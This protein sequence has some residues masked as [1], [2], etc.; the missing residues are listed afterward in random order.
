MNLFL[1]VLGV[2]IVVLW[3]AERRVRQQAAASPYIG[4]DKHGRPWGNGSSAYPVY[5]S[6]GYGC[7]HHGGHDCSSGH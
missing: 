5:D 6:S 4:C 7:N 2:L 1:V 3:L